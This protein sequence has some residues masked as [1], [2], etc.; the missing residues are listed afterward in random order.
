MGNA[1]RLAEV[2][3]QFPGSWTAIAGVKRKARDPRKLQ[4]TS[5]R[6]PEELQ[7]ASRWP[8]D[9]SKMALEGVKVT[10]DRPKGWEW[11]KQAPKEALGGR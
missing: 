5:R 10:E 4:E 1:C 11:G 2:V 8:Q 7:E 9:G 3:P 6:G